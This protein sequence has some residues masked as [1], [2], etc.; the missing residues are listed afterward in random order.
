MAVCQHGG[1]AKSHAVLLLGSTLFV[2]C[3]EP[4]FR[5]VSFFNHSSSTQS[6]DLTSSTASGHR[7]LVDAWTPRQRPLLTACDD[8][9]RDAAPG[10]GRYR[11]LMISKLAWADLFVMGQYMYILYWNHNPPPRLVTA[12]QV[13]LDL[14]VHYGHNDFTSV[15]ATLSATLSIIEMT[16]TNLRCGLYLYVLVART[17]YYLW[18]N[19]HI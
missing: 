19:I 14:C 11:S 2:L 16:D 12:L 8:Y 13:N 1:S 4:C 7:T 3:H 5:A 17:L 15:C 10:A 6:P 18:K 9:C